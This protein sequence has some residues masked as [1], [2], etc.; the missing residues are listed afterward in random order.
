MLARHA[1]PVLLVLAAT[2]GATL[3]PAPAEGQQEVVDGFHGYAWGTHGAGIPEIAAAPRVGKKDGLDIHSAEVRFLDREV[4]AGF[5]LHPATGVLVEGAYVFHV[6]LA[7][8]QETWERVLDTLKRRYPGLPLE[9]RRTR[10]A[11]KDRAVY[12]SDCEHYVYAYGGTDEEWRAELGGDDPVRGRVLVRLQPV[13]RVL[14]M[15]VLYQGTDARAW[16]RRET[17]RAPGMQNPG[18]AGHAP[19]RAS[20]G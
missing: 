4:L 16:A 20:G 10:R 15:T 11:P 3:A 2:A 14:R 9:V 1:L 13:G 17:G 19:L 12:E 18:P 8:C 6:D 5:Y 7:E